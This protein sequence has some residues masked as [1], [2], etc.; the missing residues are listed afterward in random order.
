MEN[1]N[2]AFRCYFKLKDTLGRFD[3]IVECNELAVRQFVESLNRSD[4]KEEFFSE[5]SKKYGV[6]VNYLDS[7]LF[8]TRIS[9]WY[10]LSVYQQAENFFKEFR[11]EHPDGSTWSERRHDETQ[12][13]HLMRVLSIDALT[14]DPKGI[15][16]N[17]FDY[18]RLVR[19]RFMHTNT[20][21]S[22]LSKVLADINDHSVD[23]AAEFH[24]NAPNDYN[25]LDFDD[26]ILF[27]RVTKDITQQL[28]H[29]TKPSVSGIVKMLRERAEALDPEIDLKGLRV[30]SNNKNRLQKSLSRL[31]KSQYNLQE[32]EVEAI[33][34][35]LIKCGLLV[36]R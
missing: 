3:S 18:Y 15:K 28:C 14:L 32:D 31:L 33:L 25:S 17:I 12:L 27:S 19:N 11:R 1:R 36:Q 34:D 29:V 7:N 30:F 13:A 35:E 21:E 23:V 26:F 22:K 20:D 6:R 8:H 24:V 5:S 4:N 9:Q 16:C 10:I 2:F